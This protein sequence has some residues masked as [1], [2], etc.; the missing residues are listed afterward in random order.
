MECARRDR[1]V[2]E[3]ACEVLVDLL[4]EYVR[5]GIGVPTLRLEGLTR[6]EFDEIEARR[7]NGWRKREEIRSNGRLVAAVE[8]ETDEGW[9]L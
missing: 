8:F 6:D 2:R 3:H 9:K 1:M 4:Q 5:D 7:I